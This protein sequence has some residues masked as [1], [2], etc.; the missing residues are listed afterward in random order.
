MAVKKQIVAVHSIELLIKGKRKEFGPGEVI[1]AGTDLDGIPA[2]AYRD[3]SDGEAALYELARQSAAGTTAPVETMREPREPNGPGGATEEDVDGKGAGTV[4]SDRDSV[5][6]S[7]AGK[8]TTT[9]PSASGA[10]GGTV[11]T[12]KTSSA[13]PAKA[14]R[15]SDLA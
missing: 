4:A 1:P 10:A 3:A 8:T 14:K 13:K 15:G 9:D 6:T 12:D 5:G 2:D 11:A 7:Q